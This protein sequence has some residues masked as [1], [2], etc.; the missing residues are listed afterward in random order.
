[1]SE[2]GNREGIPGDVENIQ[3]FIGM[4]GSDSIEVR[5]AAEDALVGMGAVAIDPLMEILRTHPDRELLWY[6]A[7]TLSRIGEPSIEPLVQLLR[8]DAGDE[9]KRYA[10]A[11]LAEMREPPIRRLVSM[12]GDRDPSIRGYASLILCR[13]GEPAMHA[14]KEAQH[15]EDEMRR[16]CARTTLLRLQLDEKGTKQ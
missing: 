9:S 1:M 3:R 13:I 6:I 4:L 15:D 12:L 2:E 8:S 10:A 11:A 5:R 16:R 7:R 14:L